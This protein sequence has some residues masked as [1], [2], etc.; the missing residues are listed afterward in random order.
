MDFIFFLLVSVLVFKFFSQD[1]RPFI[2]YILWTGCPCLL[3]PFYCI[4]WSLS[5]R[6]LGLLH[7]LGKFVFTLR[8]QNANI[9]PRVLIH[10]LLIL[11]MSSCN[12]KMSEWV[13]LCACVCVRASACACIHVCS[14][15]SFV[16]S[17]F[18]AIIETSVPRSVNLKEFSRVFLWKLSIN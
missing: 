1:S 7:Q 8:V 10:I 4:Q 12:I 15:F 9:S 3:L 11:V 13:T 17:E 14:I 16:V 18:W 5:F 2:F 6:S